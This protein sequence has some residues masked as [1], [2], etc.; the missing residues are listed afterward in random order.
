M[1]RV[2]E[3]L[4]SPEKWIQGKTAKDIEGYATYS[5]S[6]DAVCWCLEGAIC[7]ALARTKPHQAQMAKLI[8]KNNVCHLQNCRTQV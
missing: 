8:S 4:D 3:I 1:D 7:K 2:I 5:A 6:S